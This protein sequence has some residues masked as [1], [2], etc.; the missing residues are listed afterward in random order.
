MAKKKSKKQQQ[1][2]QKSETEKTTLM[3]ALD[4][5]IVSKLKEAK[6]ELLASAQAKEEEHLEKVR[7]E[8]IEREKNKTFA[9]LL[10]EYGDS[11]SKY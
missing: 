5:D 8:K 10:N 1:T 4:S 3:D 2:P 9:E 7:Q 6:K 11:A